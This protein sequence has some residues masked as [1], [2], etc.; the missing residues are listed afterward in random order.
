MN[1]R[2]IRKTDRRY[3]A[4]PDF[5]YCLDCGNTGENNFFILRAWC[6]NTWGPSK[7]VLDWKWGHRHQPLDIDS[8]Q[9]SNWC[10][11]EDG[12]GSKKLF[13]R[14]QEDAVLFRLAH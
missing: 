10:W 5:K 11:S 13:F 3:T 7:S 6:W 12:F 1:L 14:E 9:N 2:Q 8:C 4:F